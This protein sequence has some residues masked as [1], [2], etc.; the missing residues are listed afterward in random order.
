[1]SGKPQRFV[2]QRTL[3][4]RLG[5]SSLAEGLLLRPEAVNLRNQPFEAYGRNRSCSSSFETD[6]C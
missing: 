1:M 6:R 2:H 3:R 4:N 5:L